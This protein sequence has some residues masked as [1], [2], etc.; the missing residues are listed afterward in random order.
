M[1]L[2][3]VIVCA[4]LAV[5]PLA[6]VAQEKRGPSTAD[7]RKRFVAITRDVVRAPLDTRKNADIKWALDWLRDVPDVNVDPCPFPL[8]KLTISGYRHTPKIF[9]IYVLSM[10]VFAIEQL[11]K[12]N[13]PVPQFTA[14]VEGALRAYQAIQR[15]QPDARSEDLEDLLGK[16]RSGDL[17]EFL[18]QAA[19]ACAALNEG[20]PRGGTS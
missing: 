6:S 7:E 9:G 15:E 2:A 14:G 1:R 10:G 4:V 5:I 8:Q 13:D 20:R 19:A 17:R 16:Q 18:Q 12:P 3:T 11:G